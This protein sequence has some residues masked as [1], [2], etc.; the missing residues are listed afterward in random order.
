MR[1]HELIF[2]GR[3]IT[4]ERVGEIY[5]ENLERK[6]NKLF[7]QGNFPKEV[8]IINDASYNLI[9]DLIPSKTT[10]EEDKIFVLSIL[11]KEKNK[12]SYLIIN[13]LIIQNLYPFV[14]D[15]ATKVEKGFLDKTKKESEQEQLPEPEPEQLPKQEEEPVK[16]E[17]PKRLP[18][19]K[20]ENIGNEKFKQLEKT[21]ETGEECE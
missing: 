13:E 12:K 20:E 19:I 8:T 2:K 17:T 14:K 6:I 4:Q 1:T 15:Y 18:E 11:S 9:N 3:P 21:E 5:Q 10:K 7:P 16:V